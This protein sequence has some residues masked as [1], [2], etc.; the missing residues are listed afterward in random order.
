M[1]AETMYA[2]GY[3]LK[4]KSV[5]KGPRDRYWKPGDQV[6]KADVLPEAWDREIASGHIVS[7]KLG[8]MPQPL[9]PKDRA[10]PQTK[11]EERQRA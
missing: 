5:R 10:T 6:R 7:K 8:N 1:A 9:R 4:A 3:I 2:A 11:K